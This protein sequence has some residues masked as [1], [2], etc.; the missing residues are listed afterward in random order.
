VKASTWYP[1]EEITVA[2]FIL[3][4]DKTFVRIGKDV[5][6]LYGF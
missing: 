5:K 6:T 3:V 1:P 2:G 4:D